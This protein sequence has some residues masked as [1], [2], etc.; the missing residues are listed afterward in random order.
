MKRSTNIWK[1]K[2]E[3]AKTRGIKETRKKGRNNIWTGTQ[4]RVIFGGVQEVGH[5][6]NHPLPPP[7]CF[8]TRLL[9]F[10]IHALLCS[11]LSRH[12]ITSSANQL[13]P[14]NS[15]S[16]ELE[17]MALWTHCLPSSVWRM[18]TKQNKILLQIIERLNQ[19]TNGGYK[20]RGTVATICRVAAE[21]A[22]YTRYASPYRKQN[23]AL[24]H[25]TNGLQTVGPYR[26]ITHI[27]SSRD[28]GFAS[29]MKHTIVR[30]PVSTPAT[31]PN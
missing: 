9:L 27:G 15:S 13:H 21:L 30:G 23:N 22:R 7:L 28:S 6:P 17:D 25:F 10:T 31:K 11:T 24:H 2:K 18:E 3:T 1:M 26:G 12:K 8:L 19:T 29:G 20:I 4:K 5:V 14:Q 16:S